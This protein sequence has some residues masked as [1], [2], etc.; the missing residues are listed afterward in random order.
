MVL[1]KI[2]LHDIGFGKLFSLFFL[3]KPYQ[4]YTLQHVVPPNSPVVG[5]VVICVPS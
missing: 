5:D 4:N 1:E 3:K 2:F